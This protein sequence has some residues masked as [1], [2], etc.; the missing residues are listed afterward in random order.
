MTSGTTTANVSSK[1]K[2]CGNEK[3]PK[4]NEFG[5][6]LTHSEDDGGMDVDF[7]DDSDLESIE[8]GARWL[9][10]AS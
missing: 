8:Y 9:A 2:Y 10:R 6:K 1:V 5:F 7:S 4:I 3:T